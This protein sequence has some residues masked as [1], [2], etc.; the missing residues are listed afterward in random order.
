MKSKSQ[1]TKSITTT[2]ASG[3]LTLEDLQAAVDYFQS[4]EY[5]EAEHERAVRQAQVNAML[6]TAY[7]RKLINHHEYTYCLMHMSQG[8]L[9]LSPYMYNRLKPAFEQIEGNDL[10]IESQQ[11]PTTERDQSAQNVL[12]KVNKGE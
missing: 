3:S 8:Y 7:S 4:D 10:A 1:D 2:S 6:A 9:I 5:Q 11:I 12:R